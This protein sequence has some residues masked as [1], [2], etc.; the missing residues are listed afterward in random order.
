MLI[1]VEQ[2]PI[3]GRI[4]E[5]TKIWT[6]RASRPKVISSLVP[7]QNNSTNYHI[8]LIRHLTRKQAP[9]LATNWPQIDRKLTLLTVRIKTDQVFYHF[10]A[11]FILLAEYGE[12]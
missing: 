12:N 1:F 7:F 5:R 4:I 2:E 3:S 8:Y 9:N 10:V 11:K 6:N